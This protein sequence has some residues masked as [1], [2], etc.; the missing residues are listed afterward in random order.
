MVLGGRLGDLFGLRRVF[1]TGAVLFAIATALASAAQSLVWMIAMRA[2]QGSAAALMMPTAVAITSAVWPRE[3]RGYALGILAGGSSFFAALGPVV[4]GVL[5]RELAAGVPDQR[6]LGAHGGRSD[7]R[8]RPR[9][10]RTPPIAGSSIGP[11]PACS[12]WRSGLIHGLSRGPMAGP[13][14]RRSSR[15]APSS[16]RRGLRLARAARCHPLIDFPSVPAAELP[17]G[18]AQSGDREPRAG[19]RLPAAVLPVARRRGRPGDRRNRAHPRHHPDH[20]RRAAGRADV[21]RLGGRL[22]LAVGFVVL[23]RPASPSA[24]PR[25][26]TARWR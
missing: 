11:V 9:C 25:L 7:T 4:G 15:L 12:R 6:S 26:A 24:S 16:L 2:A 23:G 19:A 1:L 18:D 13:R 5:T 8:G 20:P 3:R 22:P 21:D 17:G 10:R 14:R